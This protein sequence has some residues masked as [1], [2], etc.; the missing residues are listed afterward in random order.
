MDEDALLSRYAACG[1]KE[2]V[3]WKAAD[4]F[5]GLEGVR[6]EIAETSAYEARLALAEARL[7][8]GRKI[9]EEAGPFEDVGKALQDEG[10]EPE[11]IQQAK[12][13]ELGTAI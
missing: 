9:I 8:E 3:S 7:Q 1:E 11:P 4:P 12:V 2:M 5:M 13:S 10:T 6:R